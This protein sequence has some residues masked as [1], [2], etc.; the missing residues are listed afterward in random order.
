MC[1]SQSLPLLRK[2]NQDLHDELQ[3]ARADVQRERAERERE[4]C[5]VMEE[6]ERLEKRL[7]PLQERCE[8]LTSRVRYHTNTHI[9]NHI[10][11]SVC[12]FTLIVGVCAVNWSRRTQCPG[13]KG[14]QGTSRRR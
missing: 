5:R 4:S 3:R 2:E 14:K 12:V 9:Q 8:Q 1:V 13:L 10:L 11:F 7:L 6:R